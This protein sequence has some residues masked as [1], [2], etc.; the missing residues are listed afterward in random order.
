MNIIKNGS[1]VLIIDPKIV[2]TVTACNIRGIDPNLRISYEVTWWVGGEQ[3]C[4]YLESFEIEEHKVEKK[5]AGLVNY[6][7]ELLK[8]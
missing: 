2:G 8:V 1:K 7:R 4:E 3:K 5:K 6:E